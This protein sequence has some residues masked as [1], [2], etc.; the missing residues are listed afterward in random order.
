[1]Q[2]PFSKVIKCGFGNM[3]AIVDAVSSFIRIEISFIC[4]F[5]F[6]LFQKQLNFLHTIKG[7]CDNRYYYDNVYKTYCTIV[8]YYLLLLHALSSIYSLLAGESP[9][10]WK[11]SGGGSTMAKSFY[12]AHHILS[13]FFLKFSQYLI[14]RNVTSASM[15]CY[16]N[17]VQ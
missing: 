2:G 6:A 14:L 12:I 15:I 16:F 11:T 17:K 10:A 13:T 9:N 8:T 7:I 1:M 5:P 3:K 4:I